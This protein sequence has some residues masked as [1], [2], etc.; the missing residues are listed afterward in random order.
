MSD[1]ARA[2]CMRGGKKQKWKN[3]RNVFTLEK[4]F[5]AVQIRI[6]FPFFS[7]RLFVNWFVLIFSGIFWLEFLDLNQT[8]HFAFIL[9]DIITFAYMNSHHQ[10]WLR[11]TPSTCPLASYCTCAS[12]TWIWTLFK[13]APNDICLGSDSF[14]ITIFDLVV[15]FFFHWDFEFSIKM[16]MKLL[17]RSQWRHRQ[18]VR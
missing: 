10:I 18:S 7:F 16:R 3:K 4:V 2:R 6:A 5:D 9:L 13:M 8:E 14:P 11:L 1:G 15:V 12:C 17:L